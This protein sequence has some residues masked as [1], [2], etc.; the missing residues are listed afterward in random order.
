MRSIGTKKYYAP[1][2]Y[3]V[4]DAINFK[5]LDKFYDYFMW[6]WYQIPGNLNLP[7]GQSLIF[8]EGGG[9]LMSLYR[10]IL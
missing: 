7:S 6:D 5:Y 9:I 8:G 3:K 2:F 1:Y 10:A 4:N